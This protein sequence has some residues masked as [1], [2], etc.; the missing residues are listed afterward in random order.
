MDEPTLFK[1]EATRDQ[2]ARKLREALDDHAA[3]EAAWPQHADASVAEMKRQL[4]IV[5]N[6]WAGVR[7]WAAEAI[8]SD[9]EK[10][11]L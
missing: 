11:I 6:A 4:L 5:A 3:L 7:D 2:A 10:E 9:A 8:R 1:L